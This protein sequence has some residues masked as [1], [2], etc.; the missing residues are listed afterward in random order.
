MGSVPDK[1][2]G[3]FNSP[4]SSSHTMFQGSSH[5]LT[6]MRTRNIHGFKGLPARKGGNLSAICEPIV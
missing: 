1:V 4:S 3:F 2:V 6:E 5:P